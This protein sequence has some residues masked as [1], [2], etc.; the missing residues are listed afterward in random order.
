MPDHEQQPVHEARS[1]DPAAWNTLFQRFQLPLYSFV[2]ELVRHEQAALDIVQESF[3]AAIRHLDSLR[4]DRRFGSWLFSIAHQRVVQHWRRE[5]RAAQVFQETDAELETVPDDRENPRDGLVR[6]E[7]EAE[8]F[9]LLERLP[10]PQRAV[11]LLHF[12]EDF[13][14]EEIA[15]VTDANLGTVKSRLHYAKKALRQLWENRP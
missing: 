12:V 11:L 14:L 4:E 7:R 9:A 5:S 13:S 3:T 8:F 1:G 6:R 2:V 15:A 10:E